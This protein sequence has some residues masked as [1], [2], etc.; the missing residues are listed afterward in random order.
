LPLNI[1]GV[2]TRRLRAVE[3]R[4][5]A[6]GPKPGKKMTNRI[7]TT[8]TVHTRQR[9][10]IRPLHEAVVE[11]CKTCGS[12]VLMVKPDK[13]AEI[14]RT[15]IL[16]IRELVNAEQL[17]VLPS[18]TGEVLICCNSLSAAS[19]SYEIHIE[20]DDKNENRNNK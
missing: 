19:T 11:L 17:H 20:G 3:V 16:R 15:D 10:F 5:I 9:I 7:R 8:I 13:A 6:E 1:S 12:E 14:L 4:M 2:L 18:Q